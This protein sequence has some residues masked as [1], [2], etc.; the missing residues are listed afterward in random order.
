MKLSRRRVQTISFAAL[1]LV[2]GAVI[3]G[4]ASPQ[5]DDLKGVDPVYP[6]YAVTVMNVDSFPNFT[7]VCYDGVA[8]ITTT[9]DYTSIRLAP[10]FA[11]I[12]AAHKRDDITAAGGWRPPDKG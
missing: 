7:I 10:E 2:I 5:L 11:N 6:D 3:A 12:C 1:P 9:R 4:C 8:E